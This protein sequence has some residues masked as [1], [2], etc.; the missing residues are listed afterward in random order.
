MSTPALPAVE[1]VGAFI[2]RRNREELYELLLFHHADMPEVP[3]QIPGGSIDSGP[4]TAVEAVHREV[5]EES[6]LADLEVIRKVGVSD[7]FWPEGEFWVKRHLFLLEAPRE[8]PDTWIHSV[9]GCGSDA[10]LR[11][12]YHWLR[13]PIEFRLTGDLGI[14]LNP[15]HLPELYSDAS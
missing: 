9:G 5:R 13:P 1:K 10:R 7:W 2:I 15:G 3:L 4:E 12:A 6:G 11:F 14:F 8:T